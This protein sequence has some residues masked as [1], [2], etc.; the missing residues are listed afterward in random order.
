MNRLI[1][2]C[3]MVLGAMLATQAAATC[4]SDTDDGVKVGAFEVLDADSAI[5]VA[6][7]TFLAFE[8]GARDAGPAEVAGSIGEDLAPAAAGAPDRDL[9]NTCGTT[10]RSNAVDEP[11]TRAGHTIGDRFRPVTFG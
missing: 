3:F 4:F 9:S 2:L 11:E 7:D 1:L 5:E 6:G 8:Y 10:A